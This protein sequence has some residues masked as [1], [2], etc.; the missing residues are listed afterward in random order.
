MKRTVLLLLG[1]ATV[2]GLLGSC[3]REAPV[4]TL[5]VVSDPPGLAVTINP[6]GGAKTAPSLPPTTPHRAVLPVGRY[7][8]TPSFDSQEMQVTPASRT[9]EVN[10]AQRLEVS[11]AV[12]L[13]G[14]VAVTS[15]PAGAAVA[16]DGEPSGEV[17]PVT[18]TLTEG[19]HLLE[20]SLDGHVATG[21]PIAV[22]VDP[23]TPA[24]VD[25]VLAPAG[26]LEVASE[27]AGARIWLDGADTGADTPASLT[28]AAGPRLVRLARAG[29][30][31]S[32]DSLLVDVPE[33][34]TAAAA[35]TLVAEGSEGDLTVTSRPA[36]AAILLDGVDTG[37]VTPH[38]FSLPPLPVSVSVG[39][40]GYLEPAA[41]SATP[42]AGADTPV[43][44]ALTARRIALV[45]TVSG[46]HCVGCP[47][48]NT[49][50]ANV[51]AAG[52][53]P[54]AMLGI[55]Y[56]GPFGGPDFF[57]QAN[58]T[59]LQNRMTVYANGTSWDWAAPTL[60]FDGALAVAPD[61]TNGYPSF[62]GMVTLLQA[63]AAE[64]PGFAVDVA[65]A[66]WNADPLDV[67]VTLTS[68]RDVT[69]PAHHLNLA[70]AENPIVFDE[71][72]NDGGET[73][74]HWIC[75]EFALLENS[76][77]RA[78]GAAPA[79]LSFQVAKQA[80]W[81]DVDRDHLFAIVFVQE[82]GNLRILQA[83]AQVPAV[84]ALSG[85]TRP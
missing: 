83:G 50:L 44:F 47:A 7:Q 69:L 12:A 9:V 81:T 5:D 68:G 62:G 53:G 49:M 35:F 8:V 48:M 51:E 20:L 64:D 72:Q 26:T 32:P 67:T 3:G 11:F 4:G 23:A 13:L 84:H 33:G 38:T 28:V 57:Y 24:A 42:A 25:V 14:R 71:P 27:P 18:L 37:E 15:D 41:V 79:V 82:P 52:F 80:N 75:R 59:V 2:T 63:A 58:P 56:S 31:V 73:E 43:D 46:I 34:G 29:W 39:R 61:F 60:F 74:F 17:T 66:D 55:K 77:G 45:E 19:E 76:P 1:A 78:L 22:T 65:V 70:V 36:G 30:L 6:V 85:R 54:D 16:V 10:A 40:N 21:G